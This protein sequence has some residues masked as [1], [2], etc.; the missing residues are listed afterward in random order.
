VAGPQLAQLWLD[1]ATLGGVF[2]VSLRDLV[3]ELGISSDDKVR[4][5]L[6][7]H[8]P[9]S[10]AGRNAIELR[11]VVTNSNGE[12]LSVGGAPATTFE[13]VVDVA[14]ADFDAPDSRERV[15]T[16]AAASAALPGVFAPVDLQ[17]DGSTVQGIDGGIVDD[18]PLGHA[19]AGAPS[20]GRV[21]VIVPFPRVRTDTANLRGLALAWH[22]FDILIQE[23]L[24]RDLRRTDRV[25]QVLAQLPTLVPDAQQRAALLE[26]LGWAERR[27]VQVVE[28]R[29]DTEL[30]GDSFAGFTS[31]A[32]RQQYL[33]AGVEAAQRVLAPLTPPGGQTG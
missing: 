9:T 7:D 2:R 8:V 32:L 22:V 25:N 4:A 30:P 11:L 14:A 23:R 3:E 10:G 21:F 15:F 24:I 13:H 16:A 1:D 29:P 20:V 18:T 17:L 26:A 6:R 27:P 31:R 5:I 33:Q 28:I 12:P 19:C